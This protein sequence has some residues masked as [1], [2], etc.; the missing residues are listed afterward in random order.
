MSN[1]RVAQ[2]APRIVRRCGGILVVIAC[3]IV[4]LSE[5]VAAERIVLFVDDPAKGVIEPGTS[6]SVLAS[7]PVALS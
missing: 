5:P 7:S 2:R 1:G 3:A 6:F 4:A